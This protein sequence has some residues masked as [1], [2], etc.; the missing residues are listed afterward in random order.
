MI[1]DNEIFQEIKIADRLKGYVKQNREDGKLDISLR[2][3][4]KVKD[5]AYEILKEYIKTNELT[6]TPKSSANEIYEVLGISKKAFKN[7]YNRLKEE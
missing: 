2:S 6:L 4:G 3:I 7:A 1:F 5:E